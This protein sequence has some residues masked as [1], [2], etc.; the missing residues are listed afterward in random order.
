MP[1]NL[2]AT[3]RPREGLQSL[4]WLP[5]T[6]SAER[7]SHRAARVKVLRLTRSD[8]DRTLQKGLIPVY[9]FAVAAG[10]AATVTAPPSM[11][12]VIGSGWARLWALYLLAGGI[13][14]LVGVLMRRGARGDWLGEFVGLPLIGTAVAVYGAVAMSTLN[15]AAGRGAGVC[16]LGML[17][18]LLAVRWLRVWDDGKRSTSKPSNP[19]TQTR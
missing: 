14:C 18:S 16:L 10:I 8:V 3:T 1:V 5:R 6:T 17:A 13:V 15:S 9:S 7:T 19:P 12:E 4:D 11:L 2:P